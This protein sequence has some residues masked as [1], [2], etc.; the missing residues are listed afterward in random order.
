MRYKTGS[1]NDVIELPGE[2][3]EERRRGKRLY[4]NF[5]IEIKGVDHDGRPFIERTKT[6]NISDMGC[7]IRTE[8]HLKAG[9]TVEI[10]IIP[11]EGVAPPA[12]EAH[13]FKVMWVAR[14]PSGWSVGARMLEP[15]K[16]W[17]VN[18]PVNKK[19]SEPSSK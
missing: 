16:L 12:E 15:G 4:L 8:V 6:E 10:R 14:R 9:D 5:S 19:P 11:P 7:R 3:A 13:R 1:S 18:F 2:I 17:K